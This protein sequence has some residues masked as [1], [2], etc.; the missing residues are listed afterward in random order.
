MKLRK[1]EEKDFDMIIY[2]DLKL[3]PT[4][5]PPSIDI[6]KDWYIGEE[7]INDFGMIYE[8]EVEGENKVLGFAIILPILKKR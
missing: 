2:E 8:E 5:T 7:K 3:Y 4:G 1:I 6:L